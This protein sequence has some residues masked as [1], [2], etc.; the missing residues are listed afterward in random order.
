METMKWSLRR[1]QWVILS[2]DSLALQTS[3]SLPSSGDDPLASGCA[4]GFT[5]PW[6]ADA[7]NEECFCYAAKNVPCCGML[8]GST[9]RDCT[10]PWISISSG[11]FRPYYT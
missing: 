4:A 1:C 3:L 9:D 6:P 5:R 11:E 2:L 10:V 8:L 7:L